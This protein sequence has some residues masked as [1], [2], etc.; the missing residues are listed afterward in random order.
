MD[1]ALRRALEEGLAEREGGSTSVVGASGVGGG[2]I[3]R[4]E[5]VELEDGRRL[6]VKSNSQAPYGMFESEAAGLAALGDLGTLRVPRDAWVGEDDGVRF[7]AM[8][9]IDE[10]RAGPDFSRRFGAGLAELHRVGRGERFGFEMDNYIGATP[11]VNHWEDDWVG[12]WRV[13]RM[14]RR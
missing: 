13:G 14:T 7:L 10:G 12:F 1:R 11:Q 2:C 8:E 9:S 4:A 6:F 5:L 3:H